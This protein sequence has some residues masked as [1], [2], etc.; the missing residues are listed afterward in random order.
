MAT[1]TEIVNLALTH[2]GIGKE[3]GNLSTEQSE[4]ASAGRRVYDTALAIIVRDASW[5]F[6]TRIE[7]L[8]LVEEGPNTE[9]AYSYRYPSNCKNMRRLLSGIR[10]DNRQVRV[11]YRI[12]GDDSGLVIYTDIQDAVCEYTVKPDNTARFTDDFKLALSYLIGSM[13]APRLTRGDAY[14]LGDKALALYL[15]T[16]SRAEANAFNEEQDEEK[17]ESE[18]I[19]ARD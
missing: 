6:L 7:S 13:M 2:I 19:R 10:N 18:F 14:K 8:A 4:E 16:I 5:P 3:I 1:N 17:P 11:S 12:A 15:Q 9:W